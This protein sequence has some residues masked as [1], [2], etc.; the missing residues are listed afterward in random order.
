MTRLKADVCKVD[1]RKYLDPHGTYGGTLV[2]K[3]I[4]LDIHLG[5]ELL[6]DDDEIAAAYRVL[7]EHGYIV[8]SSRKDGG[9]LLEWRERQA[10][11]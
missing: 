2:A 3:P 8:T 1:L 10:G 4:W 7:E 11:Y 5:Y 6:F 9:W